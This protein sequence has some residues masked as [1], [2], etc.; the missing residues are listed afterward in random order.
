MA[1]CFPQFDSDNDGFL[2][3]EE[4]VTGGGKNK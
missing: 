2:S 4:F 1:A 3:R